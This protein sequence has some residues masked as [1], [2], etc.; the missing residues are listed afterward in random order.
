MSIP[1]VSVII[2]AYNGAKYIETAINSV[3]AQ[4]VTN[5][6]I[7]VVDDGSTDDTI[8]IVEQ[9]AHFHP[10][11]KL[12]RQPNAGAQ[13]A[14]NNGI[15]H[16]SGEIIGMLDQD[17]CWLP[18]YLE[19]MLPLLKNHPIAI[20]DL[21]VINSA[22]QVI[23]KWQ[24]ARLVSLSLPYILIRIGIVSPSAMLFR[25]DFWEKIGPFEVEMEV[26]GDADWLVRAVLSGAKPVS[27]PFPLW[28]YRVHSSNTSHNTAL[29]TEH[30][31][32]VLDRAYSHTDLPAN[33]IKYKPQ[34]YLIHYMAGAA[35][36]YARNEAATVHE[37]LDKAREIAPFHF[38][39]L[40]TF[41]TFLKVFAQVSGQ[42]LNQSGAKA[43]DFVAA[44]GRGRREQARLQALGYLTLALL[45]LKT[46]PR[47]AVAI[48]LQALKAW[49]WVLAEPGLYYTLGSYSRI[50]LLETFYRLR[51]KISARFSALQPQP[52]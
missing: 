49:L 7:I 14:R 11:I 41:I 19:Y 26:S 31:G 12:L 47:L 30:A 34:A 4:T 25:K 35:K 6:E 18:Q 52:K 29:M 1:L 22:G 40:Q 8:T 28:Q 15:R 50:Y 44:A 5:L 37:Y 38:F 3:L 45:I 10:K 23:N 9:I 42:D 51:Y 2:P 24:K 46:R 21:Q 43:V 20:A 17:D 27:V 36:F 13:A 39:S 16:S 33:V 48:L 32:W